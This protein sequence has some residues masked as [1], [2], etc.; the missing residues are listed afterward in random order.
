MLSRFWWRYF[1]AD[2]GSVMMEQY[3]DV[4]RCKILLLLREDQSHYVGTRLYF[5]VKTG[6]LLK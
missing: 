4:T 2:F 5:C 1:G 3:S 6:S